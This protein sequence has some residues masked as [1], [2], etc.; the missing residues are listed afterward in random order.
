MGT[1]DAE[2][3][4]ILHGKTEAQKQNRRLEK[5]STEVSSTLTFNARRDVTIHQLMSL[6]FMKTCVEQ[7]LEKATAT[8]AANYISTKKRIIKQHS[9]EAAK[10]QEITQYT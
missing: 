10:K 5:L 1:T 6:Y 3:R 7:F 4:S 2:W 9:I 8:T